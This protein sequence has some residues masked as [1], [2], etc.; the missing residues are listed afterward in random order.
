LLNVVKILNRDIKKTIMIGDS[1]TNLNVV[2]VEEIP[3]ILLK[4][5]YSKKIQ[6]KNITITLKRFHWY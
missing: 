5:G 1:E 6:L 4:K 3:V 2:K